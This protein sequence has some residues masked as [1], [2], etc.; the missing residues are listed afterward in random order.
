MYRIYNKTQVGT[1]TST[2]IHTTIMVYIIKYKHIIYNSG[3]VVAGQLKCVFVYA[4]AEPTLFANPL[5]YL[6][7]GLTDSTA[8]QHHNDRS[9][10]KLSKMTT[11]NC[12]VLLDLWT[13]LNGFGSGCASLVYYYYLV[14]SDGSE[15]SSVCL[16]WSHKP[17]G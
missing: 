16:M 15:G 9:F 7:D 17:N 13:S 3:A 8:I 10:V 6:F 14:T 4:A 2:F 5:T 12:M 11:V 1:F